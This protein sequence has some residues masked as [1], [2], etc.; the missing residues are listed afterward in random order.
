[1]KL[2]TKL[3]ILTFLFMSSNACKKEKTHFD[4]IFEVKVSENGT[5]NIPQGITLALFDNLEFDLEKSIL[6]FEK[7]KKMVFNETLNNAKHIF[8]H[9]YSD[10]FHSNFEL[11]PPEHIIIPN[12]KKRD[13]FVAIL[14][15]YSENPFFL[16]PSNLYVYRKI[17][18]NEN[19]S[20]QKIVIQSDQKTNF[21]IEK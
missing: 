7:E 21:F 18:V 6:S 16:F 3:A 20:I 4:V 19:I 17:T 11:T 8:F 12:V 2:L 15:Q 1:M 9:C 13:Y 10:Y 14:V 5:L